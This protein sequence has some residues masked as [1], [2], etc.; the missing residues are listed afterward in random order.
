MDCITKGLKSGSG[1]YKITN[2]NNQKCYIGQSIELEKRYRSHR[3]NLRTDKH[4]N[5]HLQRAYNKGDKFVF[6]VIELCEPDVLD[7]K[8]IAWI[9]LFDSTNRE[10]GYNFD[11]GGGVCRNK[12]P[13]T[14]KKHRERMLAYFSDESKRIELSKARTSI[15]LNIVEEIKRTLRFTDMDCVT[16]AKQLGVNADIVAHICRIDCHYYI[17]EEYNRYLINRHQNIDSKKNRIAIRMYREGCTYEEVAMKLGIDLRNAIRRIQN[18]RTDHDD[19]CRLNVI[20]R[21]LTKRTSLIKTLNKM[22]K[23]T[24]EIN[25]ILKVSRSTISKVLN[26]KSELF[27]DISQTRGKFKTNYKRHQGALNE[28]LFV[29]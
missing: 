29:S 10:N 28:C 11:S 3:N 25:R 6:E 20:N 9:E 12:H 22:G 26:G 16:I 1:I 13:E 8:E 4:P 27:T 7:Q 19:R 23:N 14:I 5:N 17:C 21:A 24:V 15:P 18:T 2:L